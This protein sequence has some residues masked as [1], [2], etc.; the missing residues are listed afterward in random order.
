M[1]FNFFDF[2]SQVLIITFVVMMLMMLIEF[3]NV[4]TRGKLLLLMGK[5]SGLQIL[6]GAFLGLIPGCIGIFAVASLYTHRLVT[7]GVLLAAAITSFGDEAF[8]MISLIPKQTF[9][10]VLILFGIAVVAGYITDFVLRKKNAIQPA[11]QDDAFKIHQ[12]DSCTTH[13]NTGKNILGKISIYRILTIVAVGLFII[14][15]L[16]GYLSHTHVIADNFSIGAAAKS[17]DCNQTEMDVNHVHHSHHEHSEKDHSLFSGENLVFLLVA[18]FTFILL[19]T[20]NNHFFEEHIWNHVIRKH[21]FKIFLWVFAITLFVKVAGLFVDVE[22]LFYQRWGKL[23]LLLFA[24]LIALLPESGPNLIILFLFMD[25][26]IPFSTLVANSILQEG[27]GG[28]LL[29]A[30]KSK[31]FL[32]LKLIK[33][34]IALFVGLLGLFFG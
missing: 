3:F 15:T 12:E 8:F 1:G 11:E 2:F 17:H 23:I 19:F 10:L 20:V 26:I 27:H 21:F 6:L 28:L 9:I 24:L 13:T 25:G 14:G 29:I 33:L 32:K 18:S 31:D 5:H 22:I 30:E 4:K 16:T 34:I 7:F